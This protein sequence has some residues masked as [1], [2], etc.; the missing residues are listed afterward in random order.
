MSTNLVEGA[1]DAKNLDHVQAGKR[2][3]ILREK[4]IDDVSIEELER[5]INT[6]KERNNPGWLDDLDK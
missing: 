2:E 4:A 5:E 6:R 1:A 3:Y